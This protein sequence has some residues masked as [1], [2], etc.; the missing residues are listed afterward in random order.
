MG[1]RN[2]NISVAS[3]CNSVEIASQLFYKLAALLEDVNYWQPKALG[4][5]SAYYQLYRHKYQTKGHTAAGSGDFIQVRF[6]ILQAFR[7][8]GDWVYIQKIKKEFYENEKFYEIKLRPCP[9]PL[10]SDS[11]ET[12][13]FFTAAAANRI[14]V[15]QLKNHCFI[16]IS[17]SDVHINMQADS[18]IRRLEN[19]LIGAIG[20]AGLSD[21]QWKLLADGLMKKALRD[22][23]E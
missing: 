10:H 18:G 4:H 20:K 6:P 12:A 17:S 2:S 1:E 22:I 5:L 3:H 8:K 13:H 9:S 19:F 15:Y 23:P 14:G 16:H 21:L 11:K 7:K